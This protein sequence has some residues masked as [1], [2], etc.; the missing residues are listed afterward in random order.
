MTQAKEVRGCIAVLSRA[1]PNRN[2][3]TRAT[4]EDTVRLWTDALSDVPDGNALAAC[5]AIIRSDEHPPT[6]SRVRSE[7]LRTS[8]E[9]PIAGE[10]WGEVQ[11]GI[12]RW[13]ANRRP[14]WSSPAIELAVRNTGGWSYLCR[15]QNQ[16]ADRAR[17]I[18]YY[19]AVT[20]RARADVLAGHNDT[21][22]S[23]LEAR[24]GPARPAQLGGRTGQATSIGGLLGSTDCD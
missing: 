22:V 24:L 1:Y 12:Q 23:A 21:M 14:E 3:V 13:G 9:V 20:Q 8:L 6:I 19:D 17:F 4:L 10:A 5:K 11:R 18:E 2:I 16:A 7:A 15:S